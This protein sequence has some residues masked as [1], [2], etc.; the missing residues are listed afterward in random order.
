MGKIGC[1]ETSVRNYLYSL[2][3]SPEE[4]SSHI[5]RGGSLKPRITEIVCRIPLDRAG[6]EA[7]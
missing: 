4:R 6:K 5:L 2:Y 1:P 3:N 7:N